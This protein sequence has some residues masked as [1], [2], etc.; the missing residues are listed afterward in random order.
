MIRRL[1]ACKH[2]YGMCGFGY[3]VGT[4]CNLDRCFWGISDRAN[5]TRK[6][7]KAFLYCSKHFGKHHHCQRDL[8]H[9][10]YSSLCKNTRNACLLRH[11]GG[12]R[13]DLV[14]RCAWSLASFLRRKDFSSHASIIKKRCRHWRDTLIGVSRQFYSPLASCIAT[15]WYSAIAE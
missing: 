11:Y 15:Q 3:P 4:D 1:L 14:K 2:S 9:L 12:S 13:R 10:L 6:A 7:V 5:G 8:L